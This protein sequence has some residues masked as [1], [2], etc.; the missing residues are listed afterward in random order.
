[1]HAAGPRLLF[2]VV[3][4][5]LGGLCGALAI[6]LLNRSLAISLADLPRL[7]L[8]FAALAAGTVALRWLAELGF[9][10]LRH[11][12]LA[13][14]RRQVTRRLATISQR[15]LE[16]RGATQ[17]LV[18]LTQDVASVSELF[19]ALPRLLIQCTVVLGCLGYLA[20]LSWKVFAFALLL[21]ILGSCGR[22]WAGRR[23]T[24]YLRG[25]RSE[26]D[27]LFSHFRALFA[28]A[29][30]LRLHAPRRKAFL[31]G[32]LAPS[33]RAV[34]QLR[35]RGLILDTVAGTWGNFLFFVAIGGVLFGA[36]A[37]LEGD[38]Q[39]QSGYALAF[40]YMMHPMELILE[41]VPELSRAQIAFE[42]IEAA[43]VSL[44]S[45]KG[46]AMT[47]RAAAPLG[48]A[49]PSPQ[50]P[51]LQPV[52]LEPRP[53]QV[54]LHQV[55]HTYVRDTEDGVFELG[56]I[57]LELRSGEV[58]FLVGGNGSGKTTLAKLLVGLY[59][60]LT[61]EVR[62]DG[63]PVDA[64]ARE[65]YRENFSAVFSDYHLFDSLLGLERHQLDERARELLL[66]LDLH[67]RVRIEA[68]TL[69]TTALSSG[70][71]KRLALLVAFLEDRPVYVFDEWSADQD[72]EYKR[73]FYEQLL[74]ELRARRKAVLVITHDDQYFGLADRCVRLEAGRL[75][76]SP[77]PGSVPLPSAAV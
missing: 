8:E 22:H 49:P 14:L 10:E 55:T 36:G 16:T 39:I 37:F 29:K 65:P 15:E 7:G 53:L 43:G 45:G 11:A 66:A 18:V 71:R 35:T 32:E 52:S 48:T 74:P 21:I 3:A 67:R 59:E 31:D 4:S 19:V 54:G 26:E 27:R 30:E 25:A 70:Q 5:L 9:V 6:A 13:R 24:D 42:R 47:E 23:A 41:A 62:L 44:S 77:P 73:V 76:S 69:S 64:A 51:S 38:A 75:T 60:P 2:A 68:G 34:E 1:M 28:G 58:V 12:S 72:P 57:D 33:V 63:A 61:G 20:W 17:L 40:L 50:P 46:K 56:P